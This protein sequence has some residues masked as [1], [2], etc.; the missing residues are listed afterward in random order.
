MEYL[1]IPGLYATQC[2]LNFS[3]TN[4]AYLV[5]LEDSKLLYSLQSNFNSFIVSVAFF[6]EYVAVDNQCSKIRCVWRVHV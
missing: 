5:I 3:T 6:V 2:N 4:T 1:N